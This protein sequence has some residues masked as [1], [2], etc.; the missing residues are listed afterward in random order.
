VGRRFVE[1]DDVDSSRDHRSSPLAGVEVFAGSDTAPVAAVRAAF[2]PD[3]KKQATS[4]RKTTILGR[5][6]RDP[7]PTL[8]RP[9][10]VDTPHVEP[11]VDQ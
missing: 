8:D 2:D 6:D 10:R 4:T 1:A 3:A 5:R 11:V 7:R 9:R